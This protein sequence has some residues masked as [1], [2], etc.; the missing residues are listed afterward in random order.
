MKYDQYKTAAACLTRFYA[1]H[2][3]LNVESTHQSLV[4]RSFFFGKRLNKEWPWTGRV[5]K[6][7]HTTAL[8]YHRNV[9]FF[10]W[11]C[12][13][14]ETGMFGCCTMASSHSMLYNLVSISSHSLQLDLSM[15][16]LKLVTLVVKMIKNGQYKMDGACWKG[17][18]DAHQ[19]LKL[20]VFIK[21][22][23]QVVLGSFQ[24]CRD[25][26]FCIIDRECWSEIENHNGV[27][28]TFPNHSLWVPEVCLEWWCTHV[29]KKLGVPVRQTGLQ[30]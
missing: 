29:F 6:S 26:R 24:L 17:F 23:F 1:A 30:S 7:L 13:L 19:F 18:Y 9:W 22:S 10:H 3:V 25:F 8:Q 16:T 15:L 14:F 11:Q 5:L 28:E 21:V 4:S 20:I 27:L 2:Q 12:W